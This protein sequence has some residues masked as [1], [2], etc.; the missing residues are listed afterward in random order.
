MNLTKAQK[1]RLGAFIGTGIA[2]LVSSML[3]L[4]GLRVWEERDIYTVRF[5]ES[6]GGL[7]RSAQVKYQGLRVGR[8]ESMEIAA[9]D[10]SSIEVVLSLAAGT[11]LHEGTQAV[12]DTSGLT[13]LK[14]I[15]LTNGDPRRPRVK[16]GSQLPPGESFLDRVTGKAEAV[17]VKAEV[18]A[19][20]LAK[21]TGDE[22][23]LRV[24]R[25]LDGVEK[26]INDVDALVVDAHEPLTDT[27]SAVAL[28]S[29]QTA[30][31]EKRAMVTLDTFDGEL[32]KTAAS[33][34][35]VLNSVNK[36]VSQ[37]DGAE[38]NK[39]VIA[40]RH[41]MENL[42]K[43]LSDAEAGVAIKD[44]S[45]ALQET[46]R[47]LDEVDLIVRAGRE[48]FVASLSYIRAAAEDL[49]EFSRIIAQDPSILLRGQEVTE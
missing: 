18:I 28:V 43:R 16:P 30:A 14:T 1:V 20:Q 49:R 9:D 29:R 45:K 47:M 19:N 42:N 11:P 44:L 3:I 17:V 4:A 24:E 5:T 46:A 48:D 23:R 25:V 39:A 31:F 38:L 15:N 13:G 8:V 34:R 37:I 21:W 22:N 7:E 12:M 40:A 35:G 27:L 32:T 26:L 6:V 36:T 10:P 33:T 41:A 2:L